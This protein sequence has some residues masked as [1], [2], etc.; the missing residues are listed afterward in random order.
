MKHRATCD[1]A[2]A[3]RSLSLIPPGRVS[4]TEIQRRFTGELI[5]S[6]QVPH[7]DHNGQLA[8]FVEVLCAEVLNAI[9]SRQNTPGNGGNRSSFFNRR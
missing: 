7:A 3:P 4:F 5:P 9:K 2:T 8:D 1:A 6:D